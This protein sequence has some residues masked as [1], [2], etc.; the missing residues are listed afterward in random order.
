M[1]WYVGCPQKLYQSL[2]IEF[3][4]SKFGHILGS[5]DESTLSTTLKSVC[6]LIRDLI[7]V[8]KT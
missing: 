6:V 1:I 2:N 5:E 7:G 8:L 4:N 3:Y